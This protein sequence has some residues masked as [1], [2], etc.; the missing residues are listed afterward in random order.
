MVGAPL[1]MHAAH[2]TGYPQGF[3]RGAVPFPAPSESVMRAARRTATSTMLEESFRLR[4]P[5]RPGRS[6]AQ[7][8]ASGALRCAATLE[9]DPTNRTRFPAMSTLTATGNRPEY[10]AWHESGHAAGYLAQGI[11][12]DYV[13][14]VGTAEIPR[15]HTQPIDG[16]AGSWGQKAL[17]S[18]SGLISG[19]RSNGWG[20]GIT[21]VVDLL[22]G[23][24]DDRFELVGY[25]TDRRTWLPRGPIAAPYQDLSWINPPRLF[26]PAEAVAFWAESE[27]FVEQVR[28]AIDALAHRLLREGTVSG[29][30]AETMFEHALSGSPALRLPQWALSISPTGVADSTGDVP[31]S[32][33]SGRH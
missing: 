6:G 4:A 28:P 20:L 19:F 10:D 13:T 3:G 2:V 14:I 15:P 24:A 29:V 18:A 23:S 32:A 9:A 12:L 22:L 25:N 17:M 1:C 26:T 8:S 30:V 27:Q 31:A 21:G 16:T 33:A 11:A 5:V 7:V